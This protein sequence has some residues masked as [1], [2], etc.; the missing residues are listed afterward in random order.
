MHRQSG[1]NGQNIKNLGKN[2]QGSQVKQETMPKV[3][4]VIQ[5]Y[6]VKY[7][8]ANYVLKAVLGHGNPLEFRLL[9]PCTMICG[10]K[11]TCSDAK[12]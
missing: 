7:S 3:L 5:D 1:L 8:R 2:E 10:F 6:S 4:R 9:L 11:N 12:N